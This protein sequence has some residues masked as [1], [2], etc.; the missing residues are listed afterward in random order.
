MAKVIKKPVKKGTTH[1]DINKDVS[2]REKQQIIT[3][4]SQ[5]TKVALHNQKVLAVFI[6]IDV[7]M[8]CTV[9]HFGAAPEIKKR[10]KFLAD[11][12]SEMIPT[13][14]E[15]YEIPQMDVPT[16]TVKS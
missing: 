5:I 12:I 3:M 14:M 1:V 11:K 13:L 2:E 10:A 15:A 4:T 16:E 7:N 6:T 9:V 8:G